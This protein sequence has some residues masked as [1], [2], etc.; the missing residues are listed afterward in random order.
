MKENSDG[1]YAVILSDFFAGE[2]IDVLENR[3]MA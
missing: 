2:V 3:Q 1:K